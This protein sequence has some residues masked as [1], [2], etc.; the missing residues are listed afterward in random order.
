MPNSGVEPLEIQL[1][2]NELVFRGFTG[3]EASCVFILILPRPFLSCS[4]D[5]SL[6]GL[7]TGGR[8]RS[9]MGL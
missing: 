9:A 8:R 7:R 6:I 4:N 1:E 3:D 5:M 2:S